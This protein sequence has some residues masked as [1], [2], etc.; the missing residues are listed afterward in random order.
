[1]NGV[2]VEVCVGAFGVCRVCTGRCVLVGVWCILHVCY[3][4]EV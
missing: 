1:M 4:F 2:S 3:M